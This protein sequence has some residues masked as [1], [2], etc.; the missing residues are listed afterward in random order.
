MKYCP[1]C[2]NKLFLKELKNEGMI[3][4][5]SKCCEYKFEKFNAAVSMIVRYQ[6]KIILIKQYGMDDY[7]LVAGYINIT[8]SAE[9][10]VVRELKEELN[11]NA[12]RIKINRTKYYEK[13]NTLIINFTVF[14]DDISTLSITDEVDSYT[15]F[16]IEDAKTNIKENSLAK[17]F[18]LAYLE[19]DCG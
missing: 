11:L 16:S 5:C 4:Y 19:E 10:A 15:I 7:I 3:P 2:G 8:E 1:D 6:D 17:Y 9:E 12:S 13:S 18:L 14:V